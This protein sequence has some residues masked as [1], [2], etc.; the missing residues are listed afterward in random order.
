MV[1]S[2]AIIV[3][4]FWHQALASSHEKMMSA[5]QL[6][7]GKCSL[8]HSIDRPKA[9][10][11]SKEG[12]ES[13]VMRMKNKNGCPISDEEAMMIIDYLAEEYGK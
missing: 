3:A 10:K 11:K 8:C 1:I 6:F 13:T 12:W 5:E 2:C 7:E 9:K 4:G